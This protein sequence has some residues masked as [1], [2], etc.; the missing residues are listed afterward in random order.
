VTLGGIAIIVLLIVLLKM[1]PFLALIADR[2]RRLAAGIPLPKSSPTSSPASAHPARVGLLIALGAMLA[3]ARRLRR[4]DRVIDKLLSKH[5]D[6]ASVG[7]GLVAIIIASRCSS[8]SLV[9]LLRHRLGSAPFRTAPDAHRDP[10]AAG[11]SVLHGLIPPHP[12]L[13]PSPPYTHNSAR[14]RPRILVAVPT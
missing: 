11:L 2:V 12:A 10:G 1:H 5:P 3:T 14:P 7:D 9:L 4:A 13:I 8:R 6:V